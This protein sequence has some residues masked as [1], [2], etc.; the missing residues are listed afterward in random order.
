LSDERVRL[1]NT[2]GFIWNSHDAVF[3]ER[4]Q[5]LILFKSIH[6]HCMV[7]STYEA[8]VQ[9]AIWTKRQ[10]RQYKKYQ[11]G[12]ASSMT[13]DRIAMLEAIGFVWDC[14]KLSNGKKDSR[15]KPMASSP[16]ATAPI[17]TVWTNQSSSVKN[18]ALLA[19]QQQQQQQQQQQ[20]TMMQ[21]HLKNQLNGSNIEA[22]NETPEKHVVVK[23]DVEDDP[24]PTAMPAAGDNSRQESPQ[25]QRNLQQEQIDR[26]LSR[27]PK[28]E[29]F[30]FSRKFN[31][32]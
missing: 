28:C 14:R 31:Y 16:V 2:I 13:P 7:P 6:G 20:L 24:A 19:E 5:D 15:E 4:L 23:E 26:V 12:S 32:H 27:M 1:L 17:D 22:T 8:N 21:D 10:R 11:E 18:A 30:S 25:Q 9:L 29:F 3:A